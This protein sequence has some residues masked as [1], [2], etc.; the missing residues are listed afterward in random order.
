MVAHN[1]PRPGGKLPPPL[2]TPCS[3]HQFGEMIHANE[4][5]QRQFIDRY[6]EEGFRP[7]YWWMDA[8]WYINNGSWVN[9]GTWEVDR[10]RFPNG[11]RAILTMPTPRALRR[12]SGLSRS[13]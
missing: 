12:W 5:N 7:D 11:L 1:L 8:G 9:T 4:E 13:V 3:S 2:N 10:K 6:V